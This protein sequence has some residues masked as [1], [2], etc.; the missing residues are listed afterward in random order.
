MKYD[1]FKYWLMHEQKDIVTVKI[2]G[3]PINGDTT[4][5]IVAII[6]SLSSL[7]LLYVGRSIV[8]GN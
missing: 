7:A 5:Q 4:K 1:V 2:L 3:N 8:F 6:A